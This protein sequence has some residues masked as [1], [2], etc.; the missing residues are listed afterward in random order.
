MLKLSAERSAGAH[1]YLTTPEHT[2]QARELIGP[3]RSW[4]PNTRWC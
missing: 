2:A 4:R 1:P 3:R